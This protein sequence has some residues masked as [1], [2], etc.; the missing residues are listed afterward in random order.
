MLQMMIPNVSLHCID[1]NG[2]PLS[3]KIKI[4]LVFVVY[5]PS[6]GKIT[7]E[8]SRTLAKSTRK[9]T[10]TNGVLEL[11]ACSIKMG[12]FSINKSNTIADNSR[13]AA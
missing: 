7:L 5:I 13:Q 8:K 10:I 9:T 3:V 1:G 12:E 11:C 6:G 2:W 4:E